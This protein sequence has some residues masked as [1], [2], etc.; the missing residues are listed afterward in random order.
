VPY[1]FATASPAGLRQ[2]A[3][4]PAEEPNGPGDEPGDFTDDPELP[5]PDGSARRRVLISLGVVG[6]VLLAAWLIRAPG[7]PAALSSRPS[8][9]QTTP[10]PAKPTSSPSPTRSAQVTP[11]PAPSV[12][13]TVPPGFHQIRSTA[14]LKLSIPDGWTARPVANAAAE[15][16]ADDPAHPGAFLQFGGY[17]TAHASQLARVQGYEQARQRTDYVRL[18][19]NPVIYGDADDAVEWEYTF[20]GD[21]QLH[22][23]GRYWR[24]GKR[25]YVLY[26]LAP[27]A[28]WDATWDVL[29]NALNGASPK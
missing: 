12:R 6:L 8:A 11:G 2:P 28:D 1:P 4:E 20:R 13:V 7:D 14:G 27:E 15:Q 5:P 21:T 29:R 25:E 9:A 10:A 3:G 26:A 16:R 23:Y 18:K 24:E 22:A 19:L 17:T